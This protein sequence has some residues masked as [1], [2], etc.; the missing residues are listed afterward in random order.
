[1]TIIEI[2]DY[3]VFVK[4]GCFETERLHGQEVLV[5]IAAEL[6]KEMD[7]GVTDDLNQTIDY[8]NLMKLVDDLFSGKTVQLI[9]TI[10]N[11]LGSSL[12]SRFEVVEKAT[13]CV[14]KTI[15]PNGVAKGGRVKLS[16][17]FTKEA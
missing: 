5:S 11:D 6:S 16:R 9:E 2:I 14:E 17:V 4:L 7:A 1:M 12:I 10:L 8:G 15:L 3:P 13:I